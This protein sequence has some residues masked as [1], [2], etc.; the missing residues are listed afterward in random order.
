VNSVHGLIGIIHSALEVLGGRR[1]DRG[2]EE[3]LHE[4]PEELPAGNGHHARPIFNFDLQTKTK[5]SATESQCKR[6]LH[7]NMELDKGAGA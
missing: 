3:A 7:I 2:A 1:L 6:L 4:L 5:I